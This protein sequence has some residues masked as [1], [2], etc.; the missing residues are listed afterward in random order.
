MLQEAFNAIQV[1]DAIKVGRIY[2]ADNCFGNLAQA[3]GNGS[4]HIAFTCTAPVG[5]QLRIDVCIPVNAHFNRCNLRA[6]IVHE[7]VY[8]QQ[9]VAFYCNNGPDPRERTREDLEDEAY[10]AQCLLE[11]SQEC[12]IGQALEAQ[13]RQC[14]SERGG[15]ST[16]QNVVDA[17]DRRCRELAAEEGG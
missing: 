13:K 10:D 16:D 11:K 2:C 15:I 17:I 12:Y 1:C 8:V 5:D 14:K 9:W 6:L 3:L 4:A 7:L